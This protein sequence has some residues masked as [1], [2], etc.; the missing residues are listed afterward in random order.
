M[1]GD[2]FIQGSQQVLIADTVAAEKPSSEGNSTD[3]TKQAKSN[4]LQPTFGKGLSCQAELCVTSLIP[5]FI[6]KAPIQGCEQDG[7]PNIA[8]GKRS[9]LP[10]CQVGVVGLVWRKRDGLSQAL[11][12]L[13]ARSDLSRDSQRY[14]T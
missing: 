10:L 5:P 8:A 11:L 6:R 4:G 14:S 1:V 12:V 2:R 9:G 3:P 13:Q 7:Q